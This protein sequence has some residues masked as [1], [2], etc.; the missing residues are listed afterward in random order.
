MRGSRDQGLL[1]RV[2]AS[3]ANLGSAFDTAALALALRLEVQCL[4]IP[5]GGVELEYRG[6]DPEQVPLGP[7]NL[8][9]RGME[10][11]AGE[12][13]GGIRLV[14]RS[15]IPIGVGLGSSA[16]A[17]VAGVLIGAEL[18]VGGHSREELLGVAARLEGHP[19]NAAAALLGGFVVAAQTSSGVL[20]RR[21]DLPSQLRFVIATP[22]LALP[23]A[24]SR[25]VLPS[26]YDR[27]D[28]T[29]NLQ[30]AALLTAAFFSDPLSLSPELFADRLHQGRR[31]QLV[32]GISDCLKVRHPDLLGVF[33]SGAGSSVVGV[34]RGS[35]GE[36]G[37][38]FR[39]AFAGAG[40]SART[41]V[42]LADNQGAR[43]GRIESPA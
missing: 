42:A 41:R 5:E 35:E 32:P 25:A 8:I 31:A 11:V 18:G 22:A 13:V 10:E 7:D 17:L 28:V 26:S 14:V 1:V 19:D 38:L 24:T 2:P 34:V 43:V 27:E 6:P 15:E 30:R 20:T 21:T 37:E 39:E 12:A 23:T 9:C 40:I 4:W 33:L 16:A 29:W 3:S 36:V